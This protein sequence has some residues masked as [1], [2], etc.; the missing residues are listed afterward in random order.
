MQEAIVQHE[1]QW[2]LNTHRKTCQ[3]GRGLG[4][5]IERHCRES[6]MIIHESHK[7]EREDRRIDTKWPEHFPFMS[8]SQTFLSSKSTWQHLPLIHC[9][10]AQFTHPCSPSPHA[11]NGRSTSQPQPFITPLKLC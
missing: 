7:R 11:E 10:S 5:I 2:I 6:A 8:H 4:L 3:G 1:S 9:A